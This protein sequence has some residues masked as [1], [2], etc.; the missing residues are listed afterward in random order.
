MNTKADI[1]LNMIHARNEL[2]SLEVQEKSQKICK[3]V[4]MLPEF[5]ESDHI[6]MYADFR[7]E[8]ATKEIFDT[9]I[10][11]KKKVYFPKCIGNEMYFYQIISV[12]QLEN[13]CWG[14]K[15]P[16]DLTHPYKYNQ[17]DSTLAIIPGVAFDV[18]GYRVGYGKGYYDHFLIDKPFINKVGLAYSFQLIENIPRNEYDQKMDKIV[19]EELVYAFLRI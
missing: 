12:M 6:L 10:A 13:G 18:N 14:I 2:T 9:C 16:N 4:F 15:E 17:K 5:Q 7:H 8:V 1:R 11:Q 3:Q 19:T